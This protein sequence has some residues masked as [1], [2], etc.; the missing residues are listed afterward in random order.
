MAADPQ[1][2]PSASRVVGLA[3]DDSELSLSAAQ[4]ACCNV[5][6]PQDAVHL[7]C[8]T[9]PVSP[10][11]AGV[12]VPVAMPAPTTV[13][14]RGLRAA[15]QE[16]LQ[17]EKA[18]C[19]EVLAR[20]LKALGEVQCRSLE[21]RGLQPMGGA[22]GVARSLLEWAEKEGAGLIV[23]AR[24]PRSPGAYHGGIPVHRERAAE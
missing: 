21:V 19:G 6:R 8:V 20:T 4:W 3:V 16:E 9:L 12:P 18:R 13:D 15:Y 7:V 23:S 24:Q 11:A 22:S 10:V 14:P 17:R 1:H 5:P 2:T